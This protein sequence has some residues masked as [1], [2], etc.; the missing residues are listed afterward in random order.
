[1]AEA[2]ASVRTRGSTARA[3]VSNAKS[4]RITAD[5][6]VKAYLT[7]YGDLH[8]KGAVTPKPLVSPAY[9]YCQ[10]TSTYEALFCQH[11]QGRTLGFSTATNQ[12]SKEKLGK[13]ATRILATSLFLFECA[14][15]CQINKS[16]NF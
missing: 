12:Q 5:T 11:M 2:V 14:R 15:L 4:I 8:C 9:K 3:N 10:L 13:I 16:V 7:F 1:M 6:C